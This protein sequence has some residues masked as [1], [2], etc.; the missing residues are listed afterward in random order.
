[1]GSARTCRR[2]TCSAL[3]SHLRASAATLMARFADNRH[4]MG[5]ILGGFLLALIIGT[6]SVL[7]VRLAQGGQGPAAPRQGSCTLPPSFAADF[8]QGLM[9][10]AEATRKAR[11]EA[12]CLAIPRTHNSGTG[13]TPASLERIAT[14]ACRHPVA[15]TQAIGQYE[16]IKSELDAATS[17][18]LVYPSAAAVDGGSGAPGG[19]AVAA[20]APPAGEAAA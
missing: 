7:K 19:T 2:R 11:C 16:A 8:V 18:Q 3:A 10:G 14:Q 9:A 20:K 15:R 5:D 12:C 13:P 6:F 17:D 4:H 1:M